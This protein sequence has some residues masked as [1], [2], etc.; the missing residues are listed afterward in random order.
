MADDTQER[1]EALERRGWDALTQGTAAKFYADTMTPDGVMVLANGQA[2]SR[3]DVVGALGGSPGWDSYEMTDV[4]TVPVGVDS[5]ALVYSATA[6][7]GDFTFT[8]LM[9]SVYVRRGEHWLLALYTQT[10]TTG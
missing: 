6:S 5:A 3:D 4:R 10:P 7:R 8:G 2:M 1:L 9:T